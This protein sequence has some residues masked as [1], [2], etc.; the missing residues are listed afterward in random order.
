V[1]NAIGL[2]PKWVNPTFAIRLSARH[3]VGA[4]KLPHDLLGACF[5]GGLLRVPRP[6][7][8]G[9]PYYAGTKRDPFRPLGTVMEGITTTPVR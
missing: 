2:M 9:A 8:E 4:I 7:S 1:Q 3:S 5:V 6:I